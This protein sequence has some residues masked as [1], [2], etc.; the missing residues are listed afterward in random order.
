MANSQQG[1]GNRGDDRG[2]SR[3]QQGL[4]VE[5]RHLTG[6]SQ[7][8]KG[9]VVGKGLV[10][11]R[12]GKF[13]F[14]AAAIH[15]GI[16]VVAQVK[17]HRVARD[18]GDRQHRPRVAVTVTRLPLAAP[19]ALT[20]VDTGDVEQRQ[21]QIGSQAEVFVVAGQQVVA[22]AESH[23]VARAQLGIGRRGTTVDLDQIDAD[24]AGIDGGD[25]SRAVALVVTGQ[26][27][28]V[29]QQGCGH[30]GAVS[31]TVSFVNFAVRAARWRRI[32]LGDLRQIADHGRGGAGDLI[33]KGQV[34]IQPA[35]D[36]KGVG[37]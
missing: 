5:R 34:T 19:L 24:I 4:A 13:Q 27:E 18:R 9:A 28:T 26:I 37:Q 6:L 20:P 7:H 30:P 10:T 33:V 25:A 23:F 21:G 32:A 17:D 31:E 22:K 2:V 16:H 36:R 29:L 15:A 35:G 8:V 1:L 3:G 11:H 14:N 12:Q